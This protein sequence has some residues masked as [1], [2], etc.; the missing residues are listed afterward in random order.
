MSV[1]ATL[2]FSNFILNSNLLDGSRVKSLLTKLQRYGVSELVARDQSISR[3]LED[4]YL[5]QV[6]S[7]RNFYIPHGVDRYAE[8]LPR[9]SSEFAEY[10]S[11]K[12]PSR[13]VGVLD[14][15]IKIQSWI[16]RTVFFLGIFVMLILRSVYY[17]T[18]ES[19]LKTFYLLG[20]LMGPISG[21]ASHVPLLLAAL[22]LYKQDYIARQ[23]RESLPKLAAA[24]PFSR[25][26]R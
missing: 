18:K 23:A 8:L 12:T 26:D 7:A 20:I 1:F 5:S 11:R 4:I 9:V 15:N 14:A 22:Y 10:F 25:Q 6:L 3:R 21:G 2:I 16:G 24:A 13:K 19:A 17:G